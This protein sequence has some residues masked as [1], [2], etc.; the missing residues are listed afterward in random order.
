M[1]E[2]PLSKGRYAIIDNFDL[3]LVMRYEWYYY[4]AKAGHNEYAMAPDRIFGQAKAKPIFLHKLLMRSANGLHVDHINGNGLDNRRENLRL[5]T[6]RQNSYNSK[7]RVI[8]ASSKYKGVHL[9]KG[10]NKWKAQINKDGIHYHLGQFDTEI[11]AAEAYNVK[12]IELFGSFS[13]LNV[14]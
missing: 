8:N 12:A 5:C 10:G 9:L 1:L 4:K 14:F 6:S 2:L 11:L 7:K 3:E 13:G